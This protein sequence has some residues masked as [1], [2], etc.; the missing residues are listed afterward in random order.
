MTVEKWVWVG[1]VAVAALSWSVTDMFG[2]KALV[3][4]LSLVVLLVLLW[5]GLADQLFRIHQ[6]LERLRQ[7]FPDSRF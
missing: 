3:A 5:A 6:C 7:Q 1:W 4:V 2:W